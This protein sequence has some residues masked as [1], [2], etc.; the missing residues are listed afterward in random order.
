MAT[1]DASLPVAVFQDHSY[2]GIPKSRRFHS[3]CRVPLRDAHS[4]LKMRHS[5]HATMPPQIA[6]SAMR[7]QAGLYLNRVCF[8]DFNGPDAMMTLSA[9]YEGYGLHFKR[10]LSVHWRSGLYSRLPAR[11]GG[12]YKG[13]DSVGE[14]VLLLSRSEIHSAGA[15]E[16]LGPLSITGAKFMNW[17]RDAGGG[18]VIDLVMHLADMDFRT[19]VAWLEQHLSVSHVAGGETTARSSAKRASIPHG[20]TR[21]G[22][23]GSREI[24]LCES[25]IDSINCSQL[26]PDRICISTS[27][28]SIQSSLAKL[29]AR[30]RLRNPLRLRGRNSRRY[31]GRRDDRPTPLD[32]TPTTA[33]PRLE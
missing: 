33:R 9:Q 15:R 32:Q 21:T 27:G 3:F 11:L 26:Q 20:P 28:G 2:S 31:R 30:P 1:T 7:L 13:G 22:A 23:T 12:G 5:G 8:W 25:A 10:I 18:G 17:Q 19:A 6:S 24:V 14:V 29:P 4:C 16:L